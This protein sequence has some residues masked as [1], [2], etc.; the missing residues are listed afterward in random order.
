MNTLARLCGMIA[1][2]SILVIALASTSS[3]AAATFTVNSLGDTPDAT[4]G[5]GICADSSGTCTLRAAIQEANANPAADS[6]AFSPDTTGTI[7]LSTALPQLTSMTITGPG[8]DRLTVQ[9]AAAAETKF[10][11]FTTQ[12]FMTVNISAL[13]VTGGRSS[14]EHGGGIYNRQSTT[15]H[16]SNVV[17]SGNTTEGSSNAGAGRGGGIFS[18]GTLLTLTHCIVSGNTTSNGIFGSDSKGRDGG[19]I[20]H[21]RGTL[22]ITNS[23][24]SDNK[25]GNGAGDAG[26]EGGGL[27]ITATTTVTVTNST[28][29][30]N[31]A[32]IGTGGGRGGG[33]YIAPNGT[34]TL[35]NSTVSG[36]EA[37][38]GAGIYHATGVLSLLSCTVANNTSRSSAG[39]L[40][41]LSSPNFSSSTTLRN[42][43]VADNTANS[44]PDLSGT[45]KSQDYNLIRNMTGATFE[46]PTTH[47]VLGVDPLLSP[48]QSNEGPTQAHALLPASPAIDAGDSGNLTTDQRGLPRPVDNPSVANAS[49]GADIGAYEVQAPPSAGQIQFSSATYS[50]VEGNGFV[51]ITVT[52][53]GGSTG[54]VAATFS[55]SNGTATSAGADYTPVTNHTV[56]FADGDTAAKTI[57]I[58]INDD[59]LNE[60][61]ETVNLTLSNPAGGVTFGS[62]AAATLTISDNNDPLPAISIN[63]VSVVESNSGSV[64]AVFNVTLSPS[65]GRSVSLDYRTADGTA[66]GGSDYSPTG[67]I[68][69]FAPGETSKMIEVE[70]RRDT[71]FEVDET[72]FVNLTNAVNATI[73]DAQGQATIKDDDTPQLQ[74]AEAALSSDEGAGR[75]TL[76]VTRQ[77]NTSGTAMVEY[78]TTDTDTFTVGCAD[79]LNNN[80]GAFARCDF[81]TTVG[82]LFFAAGETDK[83]IV[84]PLIDDGH[85][86]GAETFQLRLSNAAGVGVK[87]GTEDVATIVIQDNDAA[88]A[89]NPIITQ[90]PTDYPFFVR[91][92]YLDFLSREPEAG[93]PWTGVMSRCA[94][95]NTG[96]AVVT[97][98]DRIAVSGAFFGSTEF[99]LKGFYVFRFYRL[100]FNRLPEYAQIVSDMSF[101]AGATEAEVYAR[102]AQLAT[103]FVG[104]QEFLNSYGAKTNADYVSTLMARYELTTVRTPDPSMPDGTTKVTLTKDG[105]TNGLNEGTLSR[106]QVLRAIADSDEVS[107]REFNPAFVAV[108]YYGYLRRTPEPV[109]Y[110]QNLR[111]LDAGSSKR[112]MM[113]AFL[114]STEYKLRFGRP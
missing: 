30:R 95:V 83:T 52:R 5:D 93:E 64:W 70:L 62:P 75:V 92:Q 60:P 72:F 16:L 50:T 97:D 12:T 9:R 58:F 56:E 111:A 114:N 45:F 26:G 41:T 102:K 88:V 17:V 63:D 38:Q 35:T 43:I 82:T 53:T 85:D 24:I 51:T 18:E 74:F 36:G 14:G 55:T 80:G 77:G 8:A 101:V 20:Y 4:V 3:V 86:E 105:L 54:K 109:G 107:Q 21:T 71:V 100:A 29:S 104:R 57:Q 112:E 89:S 68:I 49:D 13:T 1:A 110:E 40:F 98:C 6:I 31:K 22:S 48:L 84:V 44:N 108:Q 11:I 106:A 47:N 76:L 28:I 91:Q 69:S 19:G 27:Y 46:G 103:A 15:L 81:A 10:R 90:G 2:S 96:P 61:D 87:L 99:Q 32:G 34:V 78:R 79:A 33:L 37:I 113:N 59:S 7:S 42:T 66:E 94:D 67:G 65:S 39:G 25:A 73:S 23:T